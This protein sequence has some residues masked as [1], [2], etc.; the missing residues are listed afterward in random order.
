MTRD[1]PILAWRSWRLR[2]DP[3]TE[4]I[5]PV[6]ESCVYGDPW[7]EREAF[8]A[9]CPEHRRPEPS[10][11][12]GIYAVTSYEA[13]LEWAGWAQSALPHPIVLGRVQLWGRVLPHSA[14]YRAELGYP[15][16]LGVLAGGSVGPADARRLERLLQ[17]AYLVDIA[18]RAA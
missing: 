7:P 14:G 5:Q 10:C 4:A 12:C 11:G 9:Y 13:A 8:S 1:E 3:E 6:L 18:G 17:A 15:Y 2:I 16:E